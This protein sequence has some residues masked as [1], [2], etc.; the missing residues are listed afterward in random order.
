MLKKTARNFKK[1]K[2]KALEAKEKEEEEPKEQKKVNA[3]PG[4]REEKK[5]EEKKE[6]KE[7]DKQSQQHAKN[8]YLPGMLF[9]DLLTI[10]QKKWRHATVFALEAT[11]VI[12]F[13]TNH[14]NKIIKVR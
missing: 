6:S 2:R 1:E 14:V 9:G 4:K 13:N 10:T 11:T 7:E 3:T 5:V 8:M 12:V